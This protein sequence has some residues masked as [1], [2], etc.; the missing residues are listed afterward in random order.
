MALIIEDGSI[1]ANANS[2]NTDA[3]LVVYAAARNLSLPATETERDVLQIKAMDFLNSVEQQYQGRRVSRDQS[4]S[5]PRVNVWINDFIVH[6]DEI[7]SHLKNAQHE[8]SIISQTINLLPN[9]SIQNVQREKLDVMEKAYFK[10]GKR[11]T[12]NVTSIY[13]YL[14]PLLEDA[15]ILVRT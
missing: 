6:S 11:T 3:E 13:N 5:F 4:V 12:L 1:V 9:A 10:G 15:D 8:A 14:T 2:Y 7:P